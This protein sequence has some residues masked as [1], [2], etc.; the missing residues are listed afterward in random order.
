MELKEN[1]LSEQHSEVGTRNFWIKTNNSA[2]SRFFK[3]SNCF[4]EKKRIIFHEFFQS[5]FGV[6][7]I[8]LV[9]KSWKYGIR[10]FFVKTICEQLAYSSLNNLTFYF[11]WPDPDRRGMVRINRVLTSLPYVVQS[12][13]SLHSSSNF[14]CHLT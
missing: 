9:K 5:L 12:F 2:F 1:E 6:E 11:I 8:W 13:L 3:S 14:Y 7:N 10:L 4:V